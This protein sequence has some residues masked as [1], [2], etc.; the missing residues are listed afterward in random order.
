MLYLGPII[1]HKRD[2]R[3]M[4]QYTDE[5]FNYLIDGTQPIK[6]QAINGSTVNVTVV[7]NVLAAARSEDTLR[8]FAEALRLQ[9]ECGIPLEAEFAC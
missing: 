6:I 8:R 3:W 1:N 7:F 9:A 2:D 5:N 4:A